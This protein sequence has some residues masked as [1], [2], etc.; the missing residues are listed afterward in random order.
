M[1]TT[2]S[3]AYI[4]ILVLTA[5]VG[6]NSCVPA[7]EEV[8]DFPFVLDASKP[9]QRHVLDLQDRQATDSLVAY[10]DHPD[11]SIRYR[12]AMAF[13]SIR[14]STVIHELGNLLKDA[15]PEVRYAAAYSLGQTGARQAED[16]LIGGFDS[17]DSTRT[18]SRANAAILEAVGKTGNERSL[19]FLS[20]VKTYE[21]VDSVLI[22]GQARGIYRFA[23]RGMTVE[24]GSA[25]MLNLLESTHLPSSIRLVAAN[26]FFRAKDVPTVEYLPSLIPL[27]GSERDPEIRMCIATAIGKSGRPDAFRTLRNRFYSERDYRVKCNILRAMRYFRYNDVHDFVL[28]ATTENNL[29]VATTAANHVLA[30]G[31]RGYAL[32]YRAVAR[33]QLPWE[34]KSV[35]YGAANKFLSRQY[36]I[37]KG[38][39]HNELSL[40]FSRATNPYERAA[41][42]RAIGVEHTQY[43]EVY[44]LGYKDPDAVVRTTAVQILSGIVADT[45]LDSK[46]GRSAAQTIRQA[47]TGYLLEA[48]N[49]ND[50][51]MMAEATAGLASETIRSEATPMTS[52]IR[53]VMSKL[54]QVAAIETWNALARCVATI[55]GTEFTPARVDFNHPVDWTELQRLD[56][57]VRAEIVTSKG[58]ILM[59]LYTDW[60]PATVINFATLAGDRFYHGK[61]FHRVVPNFVIQGAVAPAAMVM[62]ALTTQYDPSSAR[63]TTT[64]PAISGWQVPE[65]TRNAP[66][67][68]SLTHRRHTSMATTRSL[69]RSNPG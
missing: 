5:V 61:K 13:A 66:S 2:A 27:F 22:L 35:L 67:G 54:D 40:W 42:L 1:L 46:V 12:A 17:F 4:T 63:F 14:D 47:I 45:E 33:G 7:D 56:D 55:E 25:A 6:L 49:S 69:E 11:P 23:L 53:E 43:E 19:K 57:T 62:A 44:N 30:A 59:E 34:V 41:V 16:I 60:A 24:Q 38:N 31:N 26:Y 20:T 37:T 8:V 29:H 65:I 52:R 48:I 64:M 58:S 10:L 3:K 9:D 32:E 18:Y 51:G 28:N 21:S 39:I 15:H 50:I 36:A 68:L